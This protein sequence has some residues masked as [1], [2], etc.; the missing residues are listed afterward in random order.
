MLTLALMH[1]NHQRMPSYLMG[2]RTPSTKCCHL[3]SVFSFSVYCSLLVTILGRS[4]ENKEPCFMALFCVLFKLKRLQSAELILIMEANRNASVLNRKSIGL[5]HHPER[6]CCSQLF[7][8]ATQC[9]DQNAWTRLQWVRVW[10]WYVTLRVRSP[11]IPLWRQGSTCTCSN[12]IYKL[13][14]LLF[15]PNFTTLKLICY[16]SCFSSNPR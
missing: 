10:V 15:W 12:D 13:K 9:A 7:E 8:E 4:V 5:Y 6:F 3:W 1:L 11:G 16:L 14:S 2:S